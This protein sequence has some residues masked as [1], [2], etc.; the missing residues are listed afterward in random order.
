MSQIVELSDI[1]MLSPSP[2]SSC[3]DPECHSEWDK[4]V[5]LLVGFWGEG[6]DGVSTM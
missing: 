5:T 6:N 3:S 1:L 2:P 4:D